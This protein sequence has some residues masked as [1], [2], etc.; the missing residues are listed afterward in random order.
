M[1]HPIHLFTPPLQE[2]FTIAQI[3]DLHLS[4]HH[5]ANTDKFLAVLQHALTHHPDLILLTGDLVNDGVT[6][7]YDW[8]F[9]KLQDTQI[10]FLCLAGNH[11]VTHE[12][13][14]DLPFD[15][16][17][18]LPL[19]KDSRLIDTHR[20]I[21]TLPHI[22]WQI[23]AVNSAVGGQIHGRLDDDKLQFLQAHITHDMP[24]LI[25]MHHHP[26][27]VGSA[28]IDAHQLSNGD[29]FWQ[30]LASAKMHHPH[31]ICGHVHQALILKQPSGTLYTCPATSRQFIPHH[32]GFGIDNVTSGFRLL[33]LYNNCTLDTQ[34]K[35][36]DNSKF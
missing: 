28:W 27:P 4:T 30:I 21:I 20:L 25:A 10:P 9:D 6:H 15:E 33:Q 13:G 26:T 2:Y 1:N 7:W 12:I 18:F 34:V 32:D 16:R 8:L 31:V 14:H 5:P 22:T 23:L 3:S 36:L 17:Q 24:T 19:A 29:A 11:D 35:R